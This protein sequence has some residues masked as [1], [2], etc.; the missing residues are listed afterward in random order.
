MKYTGTLLFSA[1]ILGIG[2]LS[3][4][5]SKKILIDLNTVAIDTTLRVEVGKEIMVSVYENLSTGYM[6]NLEGTNS[7]IQLVKEQ[8]ATKKQPKNL[9]GAGGTKIYLFKAL[10]S[11][12][13]KL[14]FTYGRGWEPGD[15]MNKNIFLTIK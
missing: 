12:E 8:Y 1:A 2:F 3:S 14:S 10:N 9:V 7:S 13:C 11:G 6:W 15:G 4:C 5:S